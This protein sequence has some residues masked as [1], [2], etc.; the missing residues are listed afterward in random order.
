MLLPQEASKSPLLRAGCIALSVCLVASAIFMIWQARTIA[1]LR[2]EVAESQEDLRALAAAT[3]EPPGISPDAQRTRHQELEV[4]R[5]RN[6]V[7]ELNENLADSHAREQSANVKAAI[8]SVLPATQSGP[9]KFQPEWKG[10]EANASNQYAQ[11][12][13]TLTTTTNEY[14]RYI[15]VSRAAKLSFAVYRTEDARRFAKDAL[16][17][18]DKYSRGVPDAANG[19]VVHDANLVLGRI[20]VHEGRLEEAKRNL[21]AAGQSHGSPSLG[22]FGPNMSLAKDLLEKGEQETVLQYMEQCRK[23]WSMGGPKLDEWINDIHAGRI[24]DFGANLV[25]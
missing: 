14:L 22:T 8:R 9:W 4:I 24:P 12:M 3:N 23:F 7:R 25:Y 10:M 6:Q 1:G 5:L 13:T 18:D 16:T 17:L 11:L 19:D 21:L 15:T 20:A 2:A